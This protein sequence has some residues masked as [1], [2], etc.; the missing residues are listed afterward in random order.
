[1]YL[2][3][4]GLMPR[5]LHAVTEATMARIRAHGFT[6]TACRYSE[7][8]ATTK[9]N[10][11]RLRAVMD[12]GG[13]APCQAMAHHPDLIAADPE[14]RREGIRSLQHMCKVTQWLGAG[15]LYVRPGSLNARGSWYPHP[16]NFA[17]VTFDIL[18]DSL[19]QVCAAAEEFGVLLAIEGH[20]LSILDTPAR[21]GELIDAVGS[22]TLRFNM[23]PVNFVGGVRDAYDT[24]SMLD[25]LF[26]ALGR[27]T[28]CGHAKDFVLQDR[29]VIHIEEAVIGEGLLDQATF[30][31]RF[32]ESCPDGYVQIEHLPDDKIPQARASLYQAGLDAGIAWKG[33]ES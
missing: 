3:I 18:V 12:S 17:A 20:V 22:D 13:V 4:Q 8:L 21:V 6:G 23:D 1:M 27:Y 7:P 28:I 26:D 14:E 15:N 10:V 32:E 9:A 30:L 19:K 2:G 29:L 24:T 31:R 16:D 25:R 11:R 5:D 33:L